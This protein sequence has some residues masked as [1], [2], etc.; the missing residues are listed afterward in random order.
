M[1]NRVQI[2][3]LIKK[4][5]DKSELSI[6]EFAGLIGC[7]RD[8]VYDIFRR[9]RINTD[10]LLKISKV[11]KYDFFKRYSEQVN[12]EMMTQIHIT[13]NIPTKEIEKGNICEY[14]EKNKNSK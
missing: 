8:N 2:G 7:N 4:Q 1:K 9:E 14:C 3:K 6:E 11:L 13:I 5:F 10:Q 12:N